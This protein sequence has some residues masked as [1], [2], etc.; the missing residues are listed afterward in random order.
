M[1]APNTCQS[2]RFR[3]EEA[4]KSV[5]PSRFHADHI[6]T[7]RADPI[8][9]PFDAFRNVRRERGFKKKNGG[10]TKAVPAVKENPS[11]S[12][13]FRHTRRKRRL[14]PSQKPLAGNIHSIEGLGQRKKSEKPHSASFPCRCRNAC[15]I[16]RG[17]DFFGMRRARMAILERKRKPNPRPGRERTGITREKNDA[18]RTRSGFRYVPVES[19][20]SVAK[21]RDRPPRRPN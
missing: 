21:H 9:I 18:I 3:K 4:S 10:F 11:H 19:I 13:P 6:E 8:E 5:L 2:E 16:N 12:I 17:Y 14:S 7:L 20:R 1:I 15:R